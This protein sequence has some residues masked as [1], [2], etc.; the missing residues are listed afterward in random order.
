MFWLGL[1]VVGVALLSQMNAPA[2]QA[3]TPSAVDPGALVISD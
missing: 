3:A 2:A 1:G